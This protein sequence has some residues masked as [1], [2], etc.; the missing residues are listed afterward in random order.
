MKKFALLCCAILLSLSIS[1][2]CSS[3][4]VYDNT[5]NDVGLWET[6]FFWHSGSGFSPVQA[7]GD[8]I[9][10][11]GTGRLV[12]KVEIPLNI[13]A[14]VPWATTSASFDLL[15]SFYLNDGA[16][17]LPGTLIWNHN[18]DDLVFNTLQE[19]TFTLTVPS[20]TVPDSF[21]WA[22]GI[23]DVEISVPVTEYVIGPLVF[24]PPTIG[25]SD[26]T[27]HLILIDGAWQSVNGTHGHEPYVFD[28]PDN[29]AIKMYASSEP[30]PEPATM[31]M[32]G[33]GLMGL[34]GIKRKLHI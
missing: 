13:D 14:G 7:I 21:T 16:G 5:T 22:I 33:L 6:V 3:E 30:I 4:V 28:Y 24:D 9:T 11:G 10:L 17:G 26:A 12:N 19:K 27:S 32:I 25:S 8:Q 29:L 31:L 15:L 34:A 1:S 20:V 18:Y 2:V 23:N